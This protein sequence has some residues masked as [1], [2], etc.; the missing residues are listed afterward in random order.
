MLSTE[1]IIFLISTYSSFSYL[2]KK[3]LIF[4]LF[5]KFL[6]FT[7]FGLFT[8]LVKSEREASKNPSRG[9]NQG[10]NLS[11]LLCREGGIT[12]CSVYGGYGGSLRKSIRHYD[13][14]ACARSEVKFTA[15]TD[16]C[17]D[18]DT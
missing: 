17:A 12:P 1:D 11:A 10:K 8:K 15:T 2:T 16:R 18:E 3:K 13:Y 5:C 6:V 7:A 4:I 14:N 9:R